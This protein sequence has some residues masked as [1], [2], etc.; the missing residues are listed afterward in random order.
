M[1]EG[2]KIILLISN[3]TPEHL[4]KELPELTVAVEL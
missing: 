1:E 4:V 3:I 2:K